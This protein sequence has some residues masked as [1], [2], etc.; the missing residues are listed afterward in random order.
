MTCSHKP[1]LYKLSTLLIGLD[2]IDKY[3][4]RSIR[5]VSS[6]YIKMMYDI[7]HLV[8]QLDKSDNDIAIKA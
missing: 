6:L 3:C 7:V 1:T 2:L 8:D 5:L 4:K